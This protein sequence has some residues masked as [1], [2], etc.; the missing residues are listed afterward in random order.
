MGLA[1]W[2]AQCHWTLSTTKSLNTLL[3]KKS[4][5]TFIDYSLQL[6]LPLFT[7]ASNNALCTCPNYLKQFSTIFSST[8]TQILW[9]TSWIRELAGDDVNLL[10]KKEILNG[11][12]NN[13]PLGFYKASKYPKYLPKFNNKRLITLDGLC[14]FI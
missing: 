8:Q 4:C 1:T 13:D 2:I 11:T 12:W 14:A 3:I 10:K 5:S 7:I 6:P 9:M